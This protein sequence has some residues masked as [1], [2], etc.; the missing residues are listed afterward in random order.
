M[1]S[2]TKLLAIIIV[3]ALTLSFIPAPLIDQVS[4]NPTGETWTKSGQLTM[5]NQQLVADSWV[6]K[7]GATYKMWF[8]RLLQNDTAA[9]ILSRIN[10]LDPTTFTNNLF[11]GNYGAMFTQ[12]SGYTAAEVTTLLG[13]VTTVIG[14]ATSPDGLTWTI[15]NNNVLSGGS[16]ILTGVGTPTVVNVSGTYHMW[17]TKGESDLTSG[18]WTT[19]LGLLAGSQANRKTAVETVLNG[20][21]TVIGHATSTN[22][23]LTWTNQNDQVFPTSDYTLGDSVGAPCVIYDSDDTTF[24]MWYTRSLTDLTISEWSDA[25]TDTANIDIDTFITA[26]DGTAAVIGY[27]TSS[28]GLTWTVQNSKVLPSSTPAWQSVGD[29]CV[30]KVG[31]TYHMW[32]T[33]ASTNLLRGGL[34]TIWGQLQAFNLAAIWTAVGNQDL[35]GILNA[36]LALDLTTINNTLASTNT[37]I[38]YATSSNGATWTV[39]SASDLTGS[40]GS[41]WSSVAAPTVVESGG[42]YEMWFT[43]GI[44]GLTLGKIVDLMLGSDFPI[45]RATATPV[46]TPYVPPYIPPAE[47]EEEEVVEEEVEEEVEGA[48]YLAEDEVEDGLFLVEVTAVVEDEQSWVTVPEGTTGL[49]A[50]G[51]PLTYIS[52][53]EMELPPPPPPDHSMIAMTYTFGPEGATFDQPVGITMTYSE[54]DLP[55]GFDEENLII[56]VWDEVTGEWLELETVVDTVNNTVTTY[57]THFATFTVLAASAPASFQISNLIVMPDEVETNEDVTISVLVE[58]TGDLSG[59]Y[60]LELQIN[61]EVAETKEIVL[62]GQGSVTVSFTVSKEVD[63]V[64]AISINGLTGRFTVTAPPVIEVELPEPADIFTSNLSVTPSKIETGDTVTISV[65]VANR[66]GQEGTYLVQLKIDGVVVE[67]R[68][69]TLAASASETITFTTSQ[70]MGGIYTVDIDNLSASFTVEKPEIEEEVVGPNWPLIGGIIGGV[71]VIAIVV[72][73]LLWRRRRY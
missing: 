41:T 27:A 5:Q 15:Q 65:R 60:I 53:V 40:T 56:V 45:G 16:D 14:Y 61:S 72:G 10:A 63:G 28:N 62:D 32:Y 20:T 39:Q 67:T 59:S 66:G 8:T 12:V 52:A 64:Y 35:M 24:K 23:G 1:K 71:V 17:Y 49:T 31:S 6:I 25:I 34:S 4:A 33:G 50:E 54:A 73:I 68:R 3:T 7:D 30:V 37:A 58:N 57:V 36:I 26:I 47:E 21:R 18:N 29:P 69:V 46:A 70:D 2:I 55:A 19:I 43:E 11:A 48:T 42:S 51:E 44:S 22:G 38:G 9:T 13:S